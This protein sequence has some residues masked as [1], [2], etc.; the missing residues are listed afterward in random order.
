MPSQPGGIYI[1]HMKTLSLGQTVMSRSLYD[2][3]QQ[4]P[5][6][7]TYCLASLSQ[8]QEGNWGKLDPAD[9]ALNDQ[10]LQNGVGRIISNYPIPAPLQAQIDLPDDRL[11]I[12]TYPRCETTLL[13]P[14][15]Y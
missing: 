9:K 1:P 11:W 15:E 14:S 10:T 12:I 4:H 6:L 2:L 5:A 8:H 13:F 3:A 7:H